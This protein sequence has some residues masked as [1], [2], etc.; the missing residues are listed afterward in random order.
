MGR[1]GSVRPG[2][3]P[4]SKGSRPL[5][6][7]TGAPCRPRPGSRPGCGPCCA[8]RR[9]PRRRA[10]PGP[11]RGA[12]GRPASSRRT[13][14]RAEQPTAR[15][16]EKSCSPSRMA[17]ASCIGAIARG[18]YTC[19]AVRASRVRALAP[20]PHQVAVVLAGGREAGMEL[21]ADLVDPG[22]RDGWRQQAV[23]ATP[24]ALDRDGA[25]GGERRDLAAGVDPGVGARGAGHPHR[26]LQ[27]RRQRVLEV[28]LDRRPVVLPLPAAQVG[29]VVLDQQP[30]LALR[31]G[32]Q[33]S[34]SAPT[35]HVVSPTDS[36]LS[37]PKPST[38]ASCSSP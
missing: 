24:H 5:A 10:G 18:A 15:N 8:G 1:R 16:A 38:L 31:H 36:L 37:L 3:G 22:H 17:A 33:N 27:D 6:R 14:V 13:V 29:A 32:R 25:G 2:S 35:N 19:Q 11:V 9:C 4:G 34:K 12:T 21:G 7:A 26:V 20:V 23:E 28:A 30:Q